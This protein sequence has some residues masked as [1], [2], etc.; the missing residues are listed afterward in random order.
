MSVFSN[1]GEFAAGTV[2]GLKEGVSRG[3]WGGIL[4]G[5]GLG[6]LAASY[7]WLGVISNVFI[8]MIGGA[9]VGAAGGTVLG[10]TLGVLFGGVLEML[11][12]DGPSSKG[13]QV[14]AEVN[15]GVSVPVLKTLAAGKDAR[16]VASSAAS[17]SAE[18]PQ[19]TS[20]VEKLALE[21]QAAQIAAAQ[22]G[23][24]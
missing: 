1:L 17:V 23:R 11:D 21:A 8:G 5:A 16:D 19:R 13:K 10:A 7:G 4:V 22:Q 15:Q 9:A 24:A 3:F 12:D 20:Y 18:P 14:K 2:N 6:A